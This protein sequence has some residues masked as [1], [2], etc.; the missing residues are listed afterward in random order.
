MTSITYTSYHPTFLD[1]IIST[2]QD[3]VY[4]DASLVYIT[5]DRMTEGKFRV[6][7]AREEENDSTLAN[8]IRYPGK[9][10]TYTRNKLDF[11]LVGTHAVHV[12]LVTE[13]PSCELEVRHAFSTASKKLVKA[14][15][16]CTFTDFSALVHPTEGCIFN[17]MFRVA[18]DSFELEKLVRC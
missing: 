10:R 4:C 13:G 6:T 5:A 1:C 2:V 9:D 15:T 12:G 11:E 14:L 18:P 17:M 3:Y 8:M 7:R 16:G